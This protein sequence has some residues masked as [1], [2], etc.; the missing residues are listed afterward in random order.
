MSGI[1][2]WNKKDAAVIVKKLEEKIK[3]LLSRNKGKKL[4]N[5]LYWDHIVKEN[6]NLLNV[7]AKHINTTDWSEIDS[8]DDLNK[9]EKYL[10]EESIAG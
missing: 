3:I 9:L 8:I 1:S 10:T 4:V 6:L 7:H 2:Y 5:N